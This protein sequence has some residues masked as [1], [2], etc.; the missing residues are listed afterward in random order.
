MATAHPTGISR[1][2]EIPQVPYTGDRGFKNV[3]T[4]GHVVDCFS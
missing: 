3:T 2:L 4:K 1:I